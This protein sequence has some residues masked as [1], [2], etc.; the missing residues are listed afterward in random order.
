M[1]DFVKC[2]KYNLQRSGHSDL[3][4]GILKIIFLR[5]LREEYLELLNMVGK[6]YISKEEFNIIRE[7]C[8][9][10][11]H[12]AAR[13]RKGVRTLKTPSSGVTKVEI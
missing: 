13:H 7:L 11:S 6:G 10:C 8:I 3:D 1:E 4:K 12:G 5:A 2:F 9:K